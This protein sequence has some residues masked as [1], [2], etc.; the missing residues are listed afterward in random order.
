MRK[1]SLNA[2]AHRLARGRATRLQHFCAATDAS[3]TL[4]NTIMEAALRPRRSLIVTDERV[5]EQ[6]SVT[7]PPADTTTTEPVA[8]ST[9]TVSHGSVVSET[10]RHSPSGAEV[11]RRAVVFVFG[12]IQ[13]LILVRIVLLLIDAN[14]ANQ[15]VRFIYDTSAFF[16][17][18]FEGVL[19]TDAVRA[20]ASVF[21]IAALV[22]LIGWTI[23]EALILAGVRIARREP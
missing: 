2:R 10:V 17:G 16:V 12:I 14:Q 1:F 7:T 23:L 21:D 20:G 19:N 8:Y 6:Q 18:P 13:A 15:L 4:G 11:A 3:I 22:A 9:G 5:V